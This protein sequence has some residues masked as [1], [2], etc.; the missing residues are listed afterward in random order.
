[1]RPRPFQFV[2]NQL[3]AAR[4]AA[5]A[6]GVG[7]RAGIAVRRA[8]HAVTRLVAGVVIGA[9]GATRAAATAGLVGGPPGIAVGDVA[10]AMI[11]RVGGILVGDL[12]MGCAG[13]ENG[14]RRASDNGPAGD[15]ANE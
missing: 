13:T 3:A 6:G 8:T 5:A 1:M 14:K 7:H 4:T 12:G 9:T 15:A 11:G 10:T 2:Y